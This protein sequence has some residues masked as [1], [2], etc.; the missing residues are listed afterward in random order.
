MELDLHRFVVSDLLRELAALLSSNL[1]SK[2]VELLFALDPEL[3][4]ALIGD[5]LRLRQVLLN[6]ASNALKFTERGE[7]MLALRL[8]GCQAGGVEIEFS[9]SDSG[10]GIAPDKL[11]S[12]F[13]GFSQAESSTTRRY[14]GTGL[15]L[16]I[17]Q[18]LV[19]LMGGQLRVESEPGKGSRFFFRLYFELAEAP[20]ARSAGNPPGTRLRVLIVDDNALARQVLQGMVEV[21]GWEADCVPSGSEAL[22]LLSQAEPQA[23][24]YQLI[25]LDWQMPGMDG[26]ETALHLRQIPGQSCAPVVVMVTAHG[27]ELLAEKAQ[28]EQDAINAFLFKPVTLSTLFDAV[29]EALMQLQGSTHRLPADPAEQPL[30]GLH[31]LLVE[32]NPLNQQIAEELLRASGAS[33]DI[34]NCGLEG[35]ARALSSEVPFDVVLMD[36]QMPDIDGFEATRRILAQK[37]EQIIIAM[38]ANAMASD[39]Q[40]CLDGG[41]RDHISKPIDLFQLRATILRHA[42]GAPAFEY[43]PCPDTGVLLQREI[44]AVAADA[45]LAEKGVADAAPNEASQATGQMSGMSSMSSKRVGQVAAAGGQPSVDAAAALA[46][47]GGN[48]A[49]YQRLLQTFRTEARAQANQLQQMQTNQDWPGLFRTWHTIKGL[50]ASAG[51]TALAALATRSE[52]L[53]KPFVLAHGWPDASAHGQLEAWADEMP[54]LLEQALAQLPLPVSTEAK[55]QNAAP[56]ATSVPEFD[57]AETLPALSELLALLQAGN[58]RSLTLTAQLQ[59]RFGPEVVP[60]TL[61][62]AVEALDFERA[63]QECQ[64]LL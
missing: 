60:P 54:L 55:A 63:V 4:P 32:D 31:L 53:L 26:W 61:R 51:A 19:G 7:V 3:P 9:V 38:T 62:G 23:E 25:L 12:I 36:L 6:L 20:V 45:A 48:Q 59:A 24:P 52:A 1:G 16:A 18:H 5:S 43:Y 64:R 28:S 10:I 47:L 14:G 50:A 42:R 58:M 2:S 11:A 44:G 37:P 49:F 34:A 17:S 15:G 41:M 30:Q 33:V 27:R 40:A 8:T 56:T 29:Q 21:L 35:V 46:R 13:E 39:R 22:A 57:P